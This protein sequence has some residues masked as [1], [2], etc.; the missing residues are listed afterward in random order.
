MGPWDV[1]RGGFLCRAAGYAKHM[2]ALPH[3][4]S[5]L[6]REALDEAC[7]DTDAK[8]TPLFR[9]WP[10]LGKR[11]LVELRRLYAERIRLAAHMG[12]LRRHSPPRQAAS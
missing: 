9:R 11:E 8:L 12:S 3:D 10:D 5:D 7:D 6:R 4:L 1:D 2:S